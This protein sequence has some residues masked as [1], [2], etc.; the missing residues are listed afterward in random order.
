LITDTDSILSAAARMGMAHNSGADG[1]FILVG[2][3]AE[4][5][6]FAHEVA[7]LE[8]LHDALLNP[9]TVVRDEAGYWMNPALPVTDESIRMKP[10]AEAL[11]LELTWVD[12]E[13]Q[14][15][16]A[17]MESFADTGTICAWTPTPPA[18]DGW[19]P[20]SIHDTDDGPVAMYVRR[21]TPR[22]LPPSD[23]HLAKR[24]QLV[25]ETMTLAHALVDASVEWERT[26]KPGLARVQVDAAGALRLQVERLASK[27]MFSANGVDA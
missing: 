26:P 5:K 18:G 7:S 27:V 17:T 13:D 25:T 16:E 24:E 21:P 4:L 12:A 19:V 20:L 8:G 22:D 3:E 23:E 6:R 15:D 9:P 1:Q 11:G 14:V 10:L 2:T